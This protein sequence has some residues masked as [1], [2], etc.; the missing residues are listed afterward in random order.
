MDNIPTIDI[1]DIN[2]ENVFFIILVEI[3][4]IVY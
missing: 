3:I 4:F 2:L 1:N